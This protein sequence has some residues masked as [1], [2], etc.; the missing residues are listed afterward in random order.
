MDWKDNDRRSGNDNRK[1]ERRG[2]MSIGV[3]RILGAQD[4]RQDARRSVDKQLQLNA[5]AIR[6]SILSRLNMDQIEIESGSLPITRERIRA[7]LRLVK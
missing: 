7:K 6:D 4:R 2:A 3:A 5:R 1:R